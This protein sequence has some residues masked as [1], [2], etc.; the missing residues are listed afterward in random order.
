[1]MQITKRSCGS[2]MMLDQNVRHVR[3]LVIPATRSAWM[4]VSP[5]RE[6]KPWA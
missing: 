4:A 5:F 6:S 3:G 2:A 1:M